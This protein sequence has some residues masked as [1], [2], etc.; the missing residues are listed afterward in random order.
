MGIRL[1]TSYTNKVIAIESGILRE[2]V[3]LNKFSV[4]KAFGAYRTDKTPENLV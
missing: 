2:K 1:S 3:K 4:S